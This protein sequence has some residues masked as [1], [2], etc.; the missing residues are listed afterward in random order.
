MKEIP[1]PTYDA[2][3]PLQMLVSDLAYS[4]YLGRLAVG[5]IFSG[6]ALCRDHLVCIGENGENT[7]RKILKLQVY[8]GII[9]TGTRTA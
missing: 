7:H 6:T 5:K 9:T 8:R 3:A 4:D 2:D 1:G